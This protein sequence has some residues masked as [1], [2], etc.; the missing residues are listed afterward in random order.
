[1]CV[2]SQTAAGPMKTKTGTLLVYRYEFWDRKTQSTRASE[3]Y[4][5]L[6]AILKGFCIP[7]LHTAKAVARSRIYQDL[8][9]GA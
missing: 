3:T 8:L 9:E 5:T 2:M 4:A 6:D 1:M 7:L